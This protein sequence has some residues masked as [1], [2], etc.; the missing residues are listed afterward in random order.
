GDA[1]DRDLD[2]RPPEV[3][4]LD[5]VALRPHR[6]AG[7]Q[8]RGLPAPERPPDPDGDEGRLQSRTVMRPGPRRDGLSRVQVDYPP[9]RPRSRRSPRSLGASVKTSP[10]KPRDRAASTFAG[11]SSMKTVRTGSR[12]K[13]SR[14]IS[15]IAGSGLMSPSHPETTTSSSCVIA[16]ATCGAWWKVSAD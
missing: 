1:S 6:H 14:R 16:G 12:P 7:T 5:R 4:R 9:S 3:A 15:K 13:R 2:R 8:L 11:R 10:R